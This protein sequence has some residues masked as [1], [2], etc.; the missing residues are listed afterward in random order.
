M[1]TFLYIADSH[2]GAGA[3]GYTQQQRYHEETPL[4]VEALREEILEAGDIDFV[5]HGGDMIERTSDE[6]IAAAQSQFSLPV[7]LHLCLGNHD[8]TE[9]GAVKRWIQGAP[10]FFAGSKEPIYSLTMTDCVIHVA[11]N[12]WEEEPYL[13]KSQQD[14]HFSPEQI[15]QLGEALSRSTHLPHILLTHSP[16]YGLPT[17]QTGLAEP[18]HPGKEAVANE[19]SRLSSRHP[20]LKCILGAHTHMNMRLNVAGVEYVTVSSLTETPFE[21][22]RFQVSDQALSMTT[23]SLAPRLSFQTNYEAERHYVQGRPVDR[24]FTLPLSSA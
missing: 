6:L 2:I 7:P 13:W 9:Q 21:C 23:L 16:A 17:E 20:N 5:L 12:H 18:F 8:M 11:P 4:I 15:Q 1:T 19:L 10:E 24:T 22:K 3:D 14:A